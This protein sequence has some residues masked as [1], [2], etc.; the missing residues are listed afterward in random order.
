MNRAIDATGDPHM[1]A[2]S[3]R[4]SRPDHWISPRPTRDPAMSR[5][6]HGPLQPMQRPGWLARL[7]GRA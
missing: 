4:S 6:I 5:L 2:Y 3:F 1:S 7:L